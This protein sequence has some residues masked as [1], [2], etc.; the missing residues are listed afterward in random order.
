MTDSRRLLLHLVLHAARLLDER[1]RVALRDVGAHHGQGRVLDALLAQGPLP[2]SRL[3]AGL[4]IA[5]PSATVMVQRME[6]AGLVERRARVCDARVVEVALTPRGRRAAHGVREAWQAVEEELLA[7]VPRGRRRDLEELLLAV[8]DH[9]GG[10]SPDF[11]STE[12]TDDV[13][14]SITPRRHR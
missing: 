2:L 1:V 5:Q 3:A 6:A 7:G 10:H 12:E 4:H 14:S 9:L 8:R 13:L 11:T